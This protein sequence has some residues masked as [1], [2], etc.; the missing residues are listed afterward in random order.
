M[1]KP[2]CIDNWY[3]LNVDYKKDKLNS[4]PLGIANEYSS[5]KKYN[6]NKNKR[7]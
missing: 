4:L 5:K 6:F 1:K 3:A 7:K 2:K